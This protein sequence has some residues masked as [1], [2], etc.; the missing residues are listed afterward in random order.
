[1]KKFIF[2]ISIFIFS[3]FLLSF[4]S[5]KAEAARRVSGYFKSNGRYVQPYYRSNLNSFKWD[6]YSARGNYNPFTGRKGYSR[7]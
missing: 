7:W 5:S 6:N 3:L 1:M 4:G 2:V